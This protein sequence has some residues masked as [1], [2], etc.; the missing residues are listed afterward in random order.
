[1]LVAHLF[2]KILCF[3]YIELNRYTW[4]F[5]YQTEAVFRF[6]L[7]MYNLLLMCN[8]SYS[9]SRGSYKSRCVAWF[10]LTWINFNPNNNK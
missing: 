7:R 9:F 2:T 8:A 4:T 1:M 3:K 5:I 6:F 10:L